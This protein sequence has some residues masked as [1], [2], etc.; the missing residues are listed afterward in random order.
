[1]TLNTARKIETVVLWATGVMILPIVLIL[2]LL[3]LM[4]KP[5]RW[6]ID[7]R[8]ILCDRVGNRLMNQSDAVKN[9]TIKNPYCLK[10]YTA[11]LAYKQL[12]DAKKSGKETNL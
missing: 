8:G 6:I 5:I 7:W 1:M 4:R 11:L 12:K 2:G 10:H 3:E 9:G